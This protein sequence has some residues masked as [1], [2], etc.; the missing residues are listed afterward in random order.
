M[1]QFTAPDFDTNH[2]YGT[3]YLAAQA[4]MVRSVLF[5]ADQY[6]Y[7]SSLKKLNFLPPVMNSTLTSKVNP[8]AINIYQVVMPDGKYVIEGPMDDKWSRWD[9]FNAQKEV[10][11]YSD[12][13]SPLF[14][15]DG[16]RALQWYSNTVSFNQYLVDRN[17]DKKSR[18]SRDFKI[19]EYKAYPQ[20]Q[21]V[22]SGFYDVDFTK[23]TVKIDL[24][25]TKDYKM[26]EI[27]KFRGQEGSII[28]RV[29]EADCNQEKLEYTSAS[30]VD[31]VFGDVFIFRIPVLIPA[32]DCSYWGI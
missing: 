10:D 9:V 14:V 4:Q 27:T 29:F 26:R 7:L 25:G 28:T 32:A 12:I 8:Y 5:N 3:S 1:A 31:E 15:S 21:V 11:D 20:Y 24:S 2:L 17:S 19:Y 13:Q 30:A 6:N 22:D 23:Y 16:K 18:E